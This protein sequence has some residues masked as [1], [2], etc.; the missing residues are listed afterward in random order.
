MRVRPKKRNRGRDRERG[1]ESRGVYSCELTQVGNGP[2]SARGSETPR[3]STVRVMRESPMHAQE[4]ETPGPHP[5]SPPSGQEW[6]AG[7]VCASSAHLQTRC[8]QSPRTPM[9]IKG[10]P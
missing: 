1:P 9:S 6:D 5:R 4:L 8:P 2:K 3:S 7:P 10:P